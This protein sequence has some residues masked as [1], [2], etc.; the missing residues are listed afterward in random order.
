MNC[1]LPAIGLAALSLCIS[2]AASAEEAPLDL[3]RLKKLNL[4]ELA[5]IPV[6]SVVSAREQ[7]I[8]EVPGTVIV[9][10]E[11]MI[12]ERGYLDL[13]DVFQDLPG[14]DVS[15]YNR[16]RVPTEVILRGVNAANNKI[17][18]LRDGVPIN[19]PA[20]T[21]KFARNLPLYDIARIEVLYGPASV[22]YGSDAAVVMQLVTKQAR[23]GLHGEASAAGGSFDPLDGFDRYAADSH[24]SL[25]LRR[26]ALVLRGSF[27][28]FQSN[29]PDLK[30]R[31]PSVYAGHPERFEAPMRGYYADASVTWQDLQLGTSFTD[32]TWPSALALNPKAPGKALL[33]EDTTFRY[34]FLQ[35]YA[36]H[37]LRRGGF[38]LQTIL[39]YGF[40]SETATFL[41]RIPQPGFRFL[42]GLTYR[43]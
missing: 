9:I 10:T 13:M 41:P 2:P 33:S 20:T 26:D 38:D 4:E 12:R 43:R 39:T 6:V 34:R 18:V 36:R 1:R 35:P 24:L 14:V 31:F 22:V 28:T 40:A 25:S 21:A 42:A 17:V 5:D 8:T 37:T 23:E 30:E 19:L 3:E 7:P 27:R 29:G 11:Q 15:M 32:H 16:Q